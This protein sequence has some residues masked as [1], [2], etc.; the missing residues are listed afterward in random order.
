MKKRVLALVLMG[1]M[2]TGLLAGCGNQNQSADNQSED[3]SKPEA[4]NAEVDVEDAADEADAPDVSDAD[5]SDASSGLEG[6]IDIFQYKVEINDALKAATEQYMALNPGVTINLETVGGGDDYGAAL[7]TRMQASD[8]PEIYNIGGPQDVIDWE[9][10]LADLSSE[11]WI[12]NTVDGL[13]DDVIKNDAVY[14]MPLAIEGYGF[15]YNKEIFEAAGI[16]ASSLKTYD[17]IDQAFGE[18]KEKI[19]NGDLKEQFPALEAVVEYP[20]KEK[21]VLG[22]HTGNIALGQEFANCTE[23]FNAKEVEFTY[24]Q[25]LKDLIDLQVKYTSNSDNAAALN[26]VDYSMQAGGGLAIERVA[27]IQQGNWVYP[28]IDEVDSE[29]AQKLGIIPLP[30]KGVSEGNTPVGV[31]MYWAVNS[32]SDENEQAIAKDFLNWLYQSDEG[33]Q[34]VVNDFGFIPPFTNYGDAKPSDPLGQA[35]SEAA[36]AGTIAPWVFNGCPTSWAENVLGAEIQSY[37]GGDKSWDEAIESA[38]QNWKE[39]R[40]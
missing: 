34:I 3:A 7:R 5:T 22:M 38:K 8:Q 2:T 29:V 30:L 33:M 35:I 12:G 4:D 9:A 20:A 31:P 16:D 19:D 37:L 10:N 23:A 27:A 36:N 40:Q 15:V 17:E 21:W 39:A 11:A 32:Q 25:E 1:V 24:G 13:L 28:I 26:A 14:G 6:T 18:L